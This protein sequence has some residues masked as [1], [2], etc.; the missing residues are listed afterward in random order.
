MARNTPEGTG[1]MHVPFGHVV[2][3]E[4][5]RGSQ[6]VQGMQDLAFFMS[7]KLIWWQEMATGRGLFGLEIPV[8]FK[9]L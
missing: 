5:W 7:L 8:I 2:A 6:L 4:K 9:G 1:P 3:N